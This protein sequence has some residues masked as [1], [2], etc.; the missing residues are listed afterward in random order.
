MGDC[1]EHHLWMVLKLRRGKLLPRDREPLRVR[2][3]RRGGGAVGARAGAQRP[4]PQERAA[5]Q[6][7]PGCWHH[8]KMIIKYTPCCYARLFSSLSARCREGSFSVPCCPVCV[9]VAA[10]KVAGS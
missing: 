6:E 3:R 10:D 5:L 7:S 1:H 2:R 9:F 8:Q 4:H